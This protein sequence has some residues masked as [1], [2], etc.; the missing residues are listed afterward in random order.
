MPPLSLPGEPSFAR[1]LL[2][3]CALASAVLSSHI[4]I[5]LN[6]PARLPPPAIGL[7]GAIPL[8]P[9][10]A[11]VYLPGYVFAFVAAVALVP[12]WK[13]FR[14]ALESFLLVSAIAFVAFW[15]YP[16]ATPTRP[17]LPADAAGAADLLIRWL[18]G[19]D[20]EANSFPSLHVSNAVICAGIV[21]AKEP[22]ARWPA[23]ALAPRS[24]RAR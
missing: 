15:F 11:W 18:Y 23:W 2:L 21:S 7:D 13:E 16:V 24:A 1:R 12:T 4:L 14:A 9:A 5:G 22:R 20:P 3:A 17:A 19:F 8:L 10:T 6:A